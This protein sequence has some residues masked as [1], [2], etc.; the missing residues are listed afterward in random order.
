MLLFFLASCFVF[1]GAKPVKGDTV[2][3]LE[4]LAVSLIIDKSGSM[5]NTDPAKMRETAA[6]IF[7]D[8]LSPEDNLGII[9]F[10]T[11]V[12]EVQPMINVGQATKAAIKGN[13]TGQ[14]E[15]GGD[16][17][18]LKAFQKANEQLSSITD[19]NIKKVIV[20]VTDGSP[21]PDPART[22]EPGFMDT[23]M[24]SFWDTIRS[25]GNNGYP[26]YS[27][28]FGSIDMSVLDRIAVETQ[29]Q[30]KVFS[31]PADVAMEFFTII[32]QLKNRNVFLNENTSLVGARDLD[33]IMDK[34]VSQATFVLA[35]T[36]GPIDLSLIPP[37]G[38]QDNGKVIVERSA[39]YTLVTLNQEE[40]EL[41][42]AWKIRVSGTT[43]LALLGAKDMFLKIWIDTPITNIQHPINDPLVVKATLTG[44]LSDNMQVEGIVLVN[45]VQALKPLT[46]TK[47]GENTYIG[48]F[49]DT[50]TEGNYQVVIQVVDEEQIIANTSSTV[51]VKVLPTLTSDISFVNE[52]FRL[53][54]SR[55]VTSTLQMGT[56][57]LKESADLKLE[58]FNLVASYSGGVEKV[59]SL[60]DNGLPENSDVKAQ[61]GRFSTNIT[62]DTE[63]A[64]KLAL[65]ARGLYKNEIFILEKE[66][67]TSSVFPPGKVDVSISSDRI[68][69]LK[70]QKIPL[71][72]T[73]KSSS[74]FPEVIQLIIPE[75]YGLLDVSKILIN[76]METKT[77]RV[78]FTPAADFSLSDFEIPVSFKAE[79]SYTTVLSNASAYPVKI[80]TNFMRFISSVVRRLPV[81]VQLLSVLV[82]LA[83][84]VIALGL[85]FYNSRFRPATYVTGKLMFTVHKD[86]PEDYLVSGKV[87]LKLKDFKKDHI[88]ITLN[89]A[90]E[91]V[92]DVYI[93][94]SK[95]SYDII[96]EKRYE[97]SRFKFIDGYKSVKKRPGEAVYIRTTEPG[98]LLVNQSIYTNME[99]VGDVIF[100]SAEYL[101]KYESAGTHPAKDPDAKDILEGRM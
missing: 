6:N 54:E 78:N 4:N 1:Q 40:T 70:N 74:N 56:V 34:Y 10:S 8:L 89:P 69:A 68:L 60:F 21:D 57:N 77:V 41:S 15:G 47:E 63:G 50:G 26:V 65:K 76:A 67:G 49:L 86:N 84:G 20:F 80:T 9:S 45:G 44:A 100:N 94:G 24:N 93:K 33:F 96:L 61:D 29:G 23:Y 28:A 95:Y 7:I 58:F 42:G 37:D 11:D 52:G 91:S 62:F 64:I 39:N 82:I 87:D 46:M 13:L 25:I 3:T 75:T 48:E 16:T 30:S 31:S 38:V 2:D 71:D 73:L 79:S 55:I 32:N 12:V 35:N 36:T 5:N 97:K 83:S 51:H 92:A 88:V 81:V 17:D 90:K 22:A 99:L 59:F 19:P 85:V 14:L 101:F 18:Y 72:L 27:V 98:I 43:E 53:G 66:V